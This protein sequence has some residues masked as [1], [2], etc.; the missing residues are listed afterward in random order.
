MRFTLYP[1]YWVAD[2]YLDPEPFNPDILPFDITENARVEAVAERFRPG[3]FDL[4]AERYGTQIRDDLQAVRYA[5]VHR[6]E[7]VAIFEN[8]ELVNDADLRRRSE[9]LVRNLAA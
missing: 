6:Y 7:P 9:T 8:A 4:G 3:T 2:P 1:I 5:I